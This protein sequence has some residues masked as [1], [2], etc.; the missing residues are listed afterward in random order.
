[1]QND[2]ILVGE[3]RPLFD[4][5][6]P[7]DISGRVSRP[8]LLKQSYGKES[9]PNKRFHV[10]CRKVQESITSIVDAAEVINIVFE[11]NREPKSWQYDW[12]SNRTKSKLMHAFL[13]SVLMPSNDNPDMLNV[14]AKFNRRVLSL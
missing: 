14:V 9:A 2:I 1:M 11:F 12:I 3:I 13:I 4:V 10:G 5:D 8:D 6:G 7:D